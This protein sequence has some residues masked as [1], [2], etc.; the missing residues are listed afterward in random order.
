MKNARSHHDKVAS[1]RKLKLVLLLVESKIVELPTHPGARARP[2]N[3]TI[4]HPKRRVVIMTLL[5][6][7]PPPLHPLQ[8]Q[9]QEQMADMQNNEWPERMV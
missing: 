7:L 8:R 3:W 6:L 4:H 2:R 9:Q 1:L 5:L